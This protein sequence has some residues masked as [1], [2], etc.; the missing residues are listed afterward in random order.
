MSKW[1]NN[2]QRVA[3][4]N[5]VGKAV[6]ATVI[7]ASGDYS[8]VRAD[9]GRPGN[10]MIANDNLTKLTEDQYQYHLKRAAENAAEGEAAG[11]SKAAPAPVPAA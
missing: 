7:D 6:T 9:D 11:A 3:L 5:A 8:R 10:P 1:M 4:R 2:G